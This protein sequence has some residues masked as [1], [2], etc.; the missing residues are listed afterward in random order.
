MY[1]KKRSGIARRTEVNYTSDYMIWIKR[2]TV[3]HLGS[4]YVLDKEEITKA[5]LFYVEEVL[6]SKKNT[7]G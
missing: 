1:I 2:A 6:Q 5:L 7:Y 3:S 4:T